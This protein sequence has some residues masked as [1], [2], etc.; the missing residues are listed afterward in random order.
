MAVNKTFPFAVDLTK[1]VT[2]EEFR[3]K[4]GDTGNILEIT[5]TDDGT[6]VNL[7]NCRVVALFTKGSN[8][9]M[10]DNWTEGGGVSI[11]G[12]S[13]NVITINLFNG[14]FA[15]GLNE[16]EVQIYSGDA[17]DV[18]VTTARFNFRCAR[19]LINEDTILAMQEYSLLTSLIASV[20]NVIDGTQSDWNEQNSS[21]VKF[22]ENKPASFM[23][24]A[25]ASTHGANGVDAITTASIGAAPLYHASQHATGGI[26]ALN[27][28]DIGAAVV[29][30]A[31]DRRE[32]AGRP[33]Y[34]NTAA[35]RNQE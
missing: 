8:L 31:A 1:P 7:S 29:R 19:A 6:P 26:D 17:L 23:P 2:N 33:R 11:G 22:I 34:R 30:H 35:H 9:A 15:P 27:P 21:S 24:T 4:Q 12:A 18:L 16:C 28:A 32:N 10:Q 5:L 20:Q 25:H 3:V 13:H 14:S